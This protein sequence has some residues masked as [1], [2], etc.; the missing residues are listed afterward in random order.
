M[1]KSEACLEV[2]V[3]EV[4]G[5]DRRTPAWRYGAFVTSVR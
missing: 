3:P 4:S 5:V 1:L 2:L